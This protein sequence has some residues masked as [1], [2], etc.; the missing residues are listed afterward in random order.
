MTAQDASQKTGG[1]LQ[2]C[3]SRHSQPL[4]PLLRDQ[5]PVLIQ[6]VLEHLFL[7]RAAAG[8][9]VLLASHRELAAA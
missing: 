5:L 1:V 3:Y 8:V 7:L 9:E 4:H 2:C 6:S